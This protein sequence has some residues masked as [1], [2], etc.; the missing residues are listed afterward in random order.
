MVSD[1]TAHPVQGPGSGIN[2]ESV[3]MVRKISLEVEWFSFC[4]NVNSAM[5]SLWT[6]CGQDGNGDALEDREDTRQWGSF[7]ESISYSQNILGP[8][9]ARLERSTHACPVPP[10]TGQGQESQLP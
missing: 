6:S 3:D 9:K 4:P 8:W 1:K 10:H 5:G 7:W 2:T